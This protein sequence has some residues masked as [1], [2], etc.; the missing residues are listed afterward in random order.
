MKNVERALLK[1]WKVEVVAWSHGLSSD[2]KNRDFR[3]R[4]GSNFKIIELDD[5]AEELLA[6]YV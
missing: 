3:Q 5:F 2:Y 6:V 1:N 4:W